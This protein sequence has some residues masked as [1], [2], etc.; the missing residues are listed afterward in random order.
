LVIVLAASAWLLAISHRQNLI[1]LLAASAPPQRLVDGRLRG[2]PYQLI[3]G[4]TRSHVSATDAHVATMSP[5]GPVEKVIQAVQRQRSVENLHASGIANLMLDKPDRA[6]VLIAEALS[7]ETG[8]EEL[9][10]AIRAS[11]DVA[12]LNDLS[13]A[14]ASTSHKS[15]DLALEAA[16]RLW[17]MDRA[18]E[19][20]W[21]RA[22]AIE[23]TGLHNEA[24]SAWR[25][26]L[27]QD[28][29][30]PWAMEA[31]KHSQRLE[32]EGVLI[33]APPSDD[34][35]ER[36]LHA[37]VR[38]PSG[39]SPN[40]YRSYLE[41]RLL[42]AL[43]KAGQSNDI[44]GVRILLHDAQTLLRVTQTMRA[45]ASLPTAGVD[46]GSV[47][48]DHP[49]SARAR[50]MSEA[51]Q[52]YGRGTA[53]YRD[54]DVESALRDFERAR[55]AVGRFSAELTEWIDFYLAC[56]A[57]YNNAYNACLAQLRPEHDAE[58][59]RHD[60]RALV[61]KRHWLRGLTFAV[62]NKRN[63]SIVEYEA[64]ERLFSAMSER[65]NVA[66][67]ASL[68]A[69]GREYL[70]DRDAAAR[71][72]RVALMLL[73]TVGDPRRRGK[74]LNEAVEAAV[75]RDLLWSALLLQDAT[76]AEALRSGRFLDAADAF[77]WRGLI[78]TRLQETRRAE[79][80]FARAA[81]LVPRLPDANVR[82]KTA[83]DLTFFHAVSNPHAV[84]DGA[85]DGAAAFY[86]GAGNRVRLSQTYR[87]RAAIAIRRGDLNR[88]EML[89]RQSLTEIRADEERLSDTASKL[90]YAASASQVAGLAA[91]EFLKRG[92]SDR[93]FS[94]LDDVRSIRSM[95]TP[96]PRTRPPY[97]TAIVV[98]FIGDEI[99]HAWVVRG[100][101]MR[102]I[103]LGCQRRH[104][105]PA[106]DTLAQRLPE[107][108]IAD[109]QVRDASSSLYEALIA[110]LSD[111]LLGA[112][113]LVLVPD[114][115]IA[116]VPFP[117]LRN[118]RSG[119]YL[120]ED[121]ILTEAPS[122]STFVRAAGKASDVILL[123]LDTAAVV[124]SNSASGSIPL[125]ELDREVAAVRGIARSVRVIGAAGEDG[126]A[127][128]IDAF[129]RSALLHFAGHGEFDAASPAD[130]ALIVAGENGAAARLTAREIVADSPA[131]KLV[132]LAAC[133][134]GRS[135]R[136]LPSAG[137][138][139]WLVAVG[140]TSVVAT[141]SRVDDA[142]AADFVGDFY[143]ALKHSPD[144]ASALRS[145]Q[146]AALRRGDVI[147]WPAFVHFGA[148]QKF[149]YNGGSSNEFHHN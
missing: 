129:A 9:T 56:C 80:D 12:L 90:I 133:D 54:N 114:D 84:D 120:I 108:G 35:I 21:N 83:A 19:T 82:K 103:R 101:S 67:V 55:A 148:S 8:E 85:L 118:E 71:A 46:L 37:D 100:D 3:T 47:L 62:Q 13:V 110:P 140:V 44:R 122:V 147:G 89:L 42:P 40:V 107:E 43:A 119:R 77:M 146:I 106:I 102:G 36:L 15:G 126:H 135:S 141:V 72:R 29:T 74:I 2:F 34:E 98:Y 24:L 58:L 25:E 88:G 17:Q 145:A 7:K 92:D 65:D 73:E 149:N 63:D 51:V 28:R 125:P 6:L 138:A 69:E 132:V 32:A 96:V 70:G 57:Y 23:K 39:V 99:S 1:E 78:W 142:A 76:V 27:L 14:A 109:R 30:S 79:A 75:N 20:A 22:L 128:A 68:V 5:L 66:A 91:Q 136:N 104:L 121:A 143:R 116:N 41:E 50:A 115:A 117:M 144:S 53:A 86:R 61:A 4:Q 26:Y 64:S 137:I 111:L 18:P 33:S 11:R 38:I 93:A 139:Q 131:A 123:P 49:G 95:E 45:D 112:R 124:M 127:A 60:W 59:L 16:L 105:R 10:A 130:S 48:I 94:L 113:A 31:K 52:L 87:L 81:G 134:S 97:G